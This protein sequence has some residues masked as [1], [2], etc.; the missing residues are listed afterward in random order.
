MKRSKENFRGCLLGGAIGDALGWPVE[1]LS[2]D[3]IKKNYG[4]QGI[5]DLIVGIS[6]KSEITDD[7]QMT[8]FTAEGLLRAESRGRE[9]GI[10]HPQ[11]VVYYAYQRWLNTQGYP[12]I[13]DLEWIYDGLLVGVKEMHKRRAPGNTCL[14]ALL[15]GKQGS[16]D[17]PIN[18]SKG[19]GGVMRVAPVGLYY[20]KENAFNIAS[21]LAALTHGHSSGYLS[22]GALAYMIAS[23]I[24]GE[25]IE[26]VVENTLVEL[27]KHENHQ[28]CVKS[29][30]QALN[31]SNSGLSDI[32]A[33]LHIGE[34]WVGEEAL[35]ISTYCT[36]KYKNDFNKALIAAVN[37]NG[38]SD[39]TGAIT[40]NIIGAYL[41]LKRIPQDWV[42]KVEL[43]EVITQLADDLFVKYQE[44]DEWWS[45]Y[46][47]Y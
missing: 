14:S 39:S 21:E 46:P 29:L 10:C 27:K 6:G 13:K 31:L 8:L 47:G 4:E 25:T 37:H 40:G 24:E 30:S 11:T 23:I 45:R 44:G 3:E 33:I 42:F 35:G 26:T 18:N 34:G 2:L 41:G 43:K 12:K 22:G 5:T 17:N 20:R 16:V 7:T 32:D 28:E 38:D 15:S 36:L 19:C 1:F 9:K